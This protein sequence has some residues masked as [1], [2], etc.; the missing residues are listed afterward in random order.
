[1]AA[2]PSSSEQDALVA[3]LAT[4]RDLGLDPSELKDGKVAHSPGCDDCFQSGHQGRTAIYEL[5]PMSEDLR[6][7]VMRQAPA[8]ELKAQAVKE[9]MRTL[10]MDGMSKVVAGMTSA[11]EIMRVTQLDV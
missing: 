10:R 8:S 1:M 5:L 7:L 3:E 9:G 2:P 11:E 6:S 4:L